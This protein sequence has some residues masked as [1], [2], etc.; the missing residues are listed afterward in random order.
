MA[1]IRFLPPDYLSQHLQTWGRNQSGDVNL[2]ITLDENARSTFTQF[3][4][5][6]IFYAHRWERKNTSSLYEG[7]EESKFPAF[8]QNAN[9]TPLCL[10]E[11][12]ET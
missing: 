11:K 8:I 1:K 5:F 2:E 6:I 4:L 7:N 10:I 12:T 9:Q 3:F